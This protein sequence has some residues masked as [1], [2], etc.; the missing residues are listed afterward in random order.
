MYIPR[1]LSGFFLIIA[2]VIAV[3]TA[4]DSHAQS[5]CV[6]GPPVD[7]TTG[8]NDLDD[9]TIYACNISSDAANCDNPGGQPHRVFW[10]AALM[11]SGTLE[12]ELVL[13]LPGNGQ[14]PL[15]VESMGAGGC[16]CR[17]SNDNPG[18]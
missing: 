1:V 4:T 12:D 13:I 8:N 10:N 18:L 11:A 15:N 3:T 7:A 16:L 14:D 2:L 17:L 9:I 5:N 6:N